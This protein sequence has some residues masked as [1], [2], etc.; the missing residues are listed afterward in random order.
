MGNSIRHSA[1][2]PLEDLIEKIVPLNQGDLDPMKHRSG[3]IIYHHGYVRGVADGIDLVRLVWP[4]IGNAAEFEQTIEIPRATPR[5]FN[6]NAKTTERPFSLLGPLGI[7][8]ILV[9]FGI[10]LLA[11]YRWHASRKHRT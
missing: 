2:Q 11:G 7:P 1:F 10:G 8:C 4:S 6:S 9:G 3:T 5:A